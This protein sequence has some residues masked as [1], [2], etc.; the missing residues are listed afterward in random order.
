MKTIV[1]GYL[2]FLND[3][4]LNGQLVEGSQD[5]LFVIQALEMANGEAT[6]RACTVWEPLFETK[7]HEKSGLPGAIQ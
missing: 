6:K 4:D 5:K 2:M 1:N 3:K 7:H